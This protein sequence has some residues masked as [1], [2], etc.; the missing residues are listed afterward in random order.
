MIQHTQE[1]E[2]LKTTYLTPKGTREQRNREQKKKK[3]E[4]INKTK[5]WFFEKIH[6][7]GKPLVRL[8]KKNRERAQVNQIRNERKLSPTPRSHQDLRE[9]TTDNYM[10]RKCTS[11]ERNGHSKDSYKCTVS[12]S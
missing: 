2:K 7:I 1:K 9:T 6:K 8:T 11:L 5:T 3:T 12:P 10:P 4:K